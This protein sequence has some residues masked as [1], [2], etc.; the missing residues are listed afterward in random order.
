MALIQYPAS[1]PGP[2]KADAVASERRLLSQ[3]PGFTPP[4]DGFPIY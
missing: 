1:L 4:T 2:S 3:F